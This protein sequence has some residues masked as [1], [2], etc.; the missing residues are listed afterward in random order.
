MGG[1]DAGGRVR[2]GGQGGGGRAGGEARWEVER[3]AGRAGGWGSRTEALQGISCRPWECNEV[4]ELQ[5]VVSP[6][7]G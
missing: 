5:V 6:M 7:D 3:Q 4:S 2:W 1:S